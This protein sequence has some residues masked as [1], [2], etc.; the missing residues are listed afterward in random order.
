MLAEAQDPRYCWR[1]IGA[2][3]QCASAI[4]QMLRYELDIRG[5]DTPI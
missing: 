2:P 4:S 3:P 5:D 1:R